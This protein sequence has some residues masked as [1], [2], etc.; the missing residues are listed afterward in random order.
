MHVRL[1]HF[2]PLL[3]LILAG[4][5]IFALPFHIPRFYRTTFLD[6]FN[7]TN[8]ELGDS[9]ALYGIVAMMAYFPGVL[10]ADRFN[11]KNLLIISL[12]TTALG[13]MYLYTI[14]TVAGLKVLFAYWGVTTILLFWSALIKATRLLAGHQQQGIT[15]GV[16]DAGRGIVASLLASLAIM[17]FGQQLVSSAADPITIL[18]LIVFYY[19]LITLFVAALVW[20]VFPSYD[21]QL[22]PSGSILSVARVTID[23][24][25]EVIGNQRVWLQASIVIAAYCGYKGIDNY[26]L[27]LTKL[28]GYNSLESAQFMTQL[29]YLRPVGAIAAGLIADRWLASRT[30]SLLFVLLAVCYIFNVVQTTQVSLVVINFVIS[31]LAVFAIRGIYFSLIDESNVSISVTGGAVGLISVIGFTPDIF[32]A[33]LAGRLLD[34]ASDGLAFQQYFLFMAGFATAGLL[35]CWLLIKT[36][37]KNND[38]KKAIG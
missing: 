34:N 28:A 1:N 38:S 30:I 36:D 25:K 22:G 17:M 19:T 4:E 31:A 15:F 18:R 26:G 23:E 20:L 24:M 16:L 14:P 33:S 8:T 2:S 6:A 13:G 37:R 9:F 27:L 12:V 7:I 11:T 3:A 29:S 10:I 21:S 32:F 5:A 35:S